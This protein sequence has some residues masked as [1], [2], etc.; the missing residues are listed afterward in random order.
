LNYTDDDESKQIHDVELNIDSAI[1]GDPEAFGRLYDIYV[2]RIYRHI[3][4]RTNNVE[5]ARDLTQEVF[6]KAWQA[7]PKYKRT[8][9]PFLGW[10]FTISHNRVI[11]YYRTRK[12][13]TYLDDIFFLKDR[14][15]T[16][17]QLAESK[18]TQQAIRRVILQLPEVQQQVVLMSFI[19]GLEYSEIAAVLGKTEGN[20][21]VI[22]HRALKTMKEMLG[23][24]EY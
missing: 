16:P 10:L 23:R 20:I 21:R 12:D 9:T 17:D 7:L 18:F 1:R 24:E 15:G 22:V 11:D 14:E 3:Y 19:E 13:Y 5:D 4:Y 2:D 8:K 6:M